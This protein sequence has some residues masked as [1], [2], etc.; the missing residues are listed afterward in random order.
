MRGIQVR[1]KILFVVIVTFVLAVSGTYSQYKL[2]QDLENRNAQLLQGITTRLQISLPSALWDLD[3]AKVGSILE[4][5][6][7]PPEVLG[8]RVFDSNVGLFIGKFR[9][10]RGEMSSTSPTSLI[11]GIPIETPLIFYGASGDRGVVKPVAVGRVVI[12]FSRKQIEAALQSELMRKLLEVLVLDVSLVVILSLSLRMVFEPL[13]QLR[14]SMSDLA[15]REAEE[16]GELPEMRVDEFG[17]V[18]RGFNQILRQLKSVIERARQ[19]EDVAHRSE[20]QTTRA[21]QELRQAQDSLVQAERLASLGGLVAGVAHEINTPVG[22]TLTSASVLREATDKIL[23]SMSAGAVKKSDIL[24]YLDIANESSRLIMSNSNRAAHLIQ[25]FKQIAADQTSEA[26][27]VFGLHGYIAEI[28]LSLHP[29][30]RQTKLKITVDCLD[31]VEV[32]SYPGAFAQILTNLI[33]NALA[34]AFAAD[35]KGG[36]H[37]AAQQNGEW[38]ELSFADDGKGI[39]E[40]YIDKIFDPFFTTQRGQGGTGLGLNIVF[41]LVVKLLVG[42][43]SVA[44]TLGQG[45]KFTIRFPRVTPK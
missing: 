35:G 4:A 38:V 11:D 1:L 6:M 20:Q 32:D 39:G 17:D 36:I 27:R 2:H 10:V 40:A 16:V 19:A 44:S 33:M 31:G 41:N 3:R 37:V 5:E 12:N 13:Q 14:D 22:I 7:L 45:T 34:H 43:I 21:F 9:N 28:I 29:R 42:T 15:T 24:S 30:L 25:S 18:A 8:I 26:R 23:Q